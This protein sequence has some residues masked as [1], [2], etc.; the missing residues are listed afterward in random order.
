MRDRT[1]F[2][3]SGS[4]LAFTLALAFPLYGQ[5]ISTGDTTPKPR[6]QGET[7]SRLSQSTKAKP[8][9]AA[10]VPAP[11]QNPAA[12][13]AQRALPKPSRVDLLS[14]RAGAL[15]FVSY[16]GSGAGLEYLYEPTDWFLGG[17][18]YAHT[19]AELGQSSS[20]PTEEFLDGSLDSVKLQ[21]QYRALR[22]V[23]FGMGLGFAK[24]KGKYGWQGEGVADGQIDSRYEAQLFVADLFLG[25]EWTLFDAFY[26]GVDWFGFAAPIAGSVTVESTEEADIT[27]QFLTGSTSE[28]RVNSEISAQLKLYYLALRAG[29]RF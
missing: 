7:R 6:K 9:P 25:S 27:T 12:V 22:P 17:I 18:S 21:L 23:Y 10:P 3:P 4:L 26:V 8:L 11:A 2:L 29:Y 1:L 13:P 16:F 14:H 19:Q 24:I 20:S 5:N 15:G 28:S